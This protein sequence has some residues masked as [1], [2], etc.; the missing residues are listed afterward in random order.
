MAKLGYTF[1]PKDWSSSDGV[2]ELNLPE[3]GLYRELID[4]AMLEDNKVKINVK[5]WSRKFDSNE[6]EINNILEKLLELKLI[7]VKEKTISIPSC[8][9]RL[10][11]VRAGRSGGLKSRKSKHIDKP[12]SKHI[13][14]PTDKQSDNQK[15][16]KESKVNKKENKKE[17]IDWVGLIKLIN[18]NTGRNFKIINAQTKKKYDKLILEGYTK[19]DIA[20]AIVNASKAE[21]HIESGYQ[22]LTPEFFSRPDKI[23]MYATQIN[24]KNEKIVAPKMN[25]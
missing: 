24:L 3:R 11:L 1:Y 25:T 22:H 4:L 5:V 21:H 20:N 17:K 15:K 13:D 8:E 19:H 14:K 2:F 10:K 12:L 9:S 18:Q 23:D 7:K 16:R 6:E